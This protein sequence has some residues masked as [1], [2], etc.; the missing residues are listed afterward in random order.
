MSN[1]DDSRAGN[2]LVGK[3]QKLVSTVRRAARSGTS[4]TTA[5]VECPF[6]RVVSCARTRKTTTNT[7]YE[8]TMV[9]DSISSTWYEIQKW[10]NYFTYS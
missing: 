8:R 2:R 1:T 3:W 5:A 10:E 4:P 7:W 9:I 6:I